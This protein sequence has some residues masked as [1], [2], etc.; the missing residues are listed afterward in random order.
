[1]VQSILGQSLVNAGD[2]NHRLVLFFA[3]KKNEAFR[4]AILIGPSGQNVHVLSY[5][6][7]RLR[8]Q[9]GLSS[10]LGGFVERIGIHGLDPFYGSDGNALQAFYNKFTPNYLIDVFHS[11]TQKKQDFALQEE[12]RALGGEIIKERDEV[13]KAALKAQLVALKQ[14]YNRIV[15]TEHPFNPVDV[16]N[17]LVAKGKLS[18]AKS[19]GWEKYFSSDPLEPGTF[20]ELTREGAKQYLI[21][22]GV[23]I[24]AAA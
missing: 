24:A 8:D 15:K 14:K 6:Y 5:Y 17:D 9:L 19:D 20:S 16:Y 12:V 21:D 1:V 10:A 22:T 7:T 2:F 11:H 23:L 13:K 4:Q 18:T 3:L